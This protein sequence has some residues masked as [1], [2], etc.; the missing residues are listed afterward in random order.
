MGG[1]TLRTYEDAAMSG[2]SVEPAPIR[3][4]ERLVDW[5]LMAAAFLFLAAYAVP[6]LSS[7][8]PSTL[9]DVCRWLSWAT[10]VVFVAELRFACP[11][12]VRGFPTWSSIGT[13]SW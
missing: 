11:W 2:T 13:T 12:H 7:S 5:P 3:R 8:A 1:G 6:I 4:W 9:L 10:W